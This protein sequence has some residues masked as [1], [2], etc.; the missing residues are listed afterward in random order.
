MK[1]LAC[2]TVG[3]ILLFGA[4]CKESS[5]KTIPDEVIASPFSIDILDDEALQIIDPKSKI[6]I[7]A[8]GFAW[9][10]GPLWIKDGNYLLFSDIPNNKIYKLDPQ[11]NDTVT[12]LH[13]SGF[14]GTDFTGEEPGSNGLLLNK[15]GELVLMQHGNRQV[16]KMNAPLNS[17]SS[18]F[19]T[20]VDSYMG[21]K[22]NSPNDATFDNNGNLYFTDPPY[23]LPKRMDDEGKELDFQGI[24]CLMT[25]GELILLDSISRPNG[26]GISPDGNVLYVANSDPEH[27]AWYQY[28]ITEPGKVAD[29]KLFYEVTNLIGNE[30]QQGLPDGLKVN[31]NGILFASG[32]GGVWIFNPKGKALARIHTGQATANC[33]FDTDQK[34]LYMTADDFIM[35]VD[36]K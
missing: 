11:N 9:T 20:L 19:T 15:D 34:R 3:S 16:A 36:L 22:L 35:A 18:E 28:K 1:K 5:K 2:I 27:A 32:P 7:L 17:P 23:G 25:S 30:G 26:I 31:N 21:K 4:S 8:S 33:A 10:E 6:E 12:Y 13:P 14:S 24:Y 29:K